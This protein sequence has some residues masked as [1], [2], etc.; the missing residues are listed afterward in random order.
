M[1]DLV[2]Y[3][4]RTIDLRNVYLV[5][6]LK[7]K[8]EKARKRYYKLYAQVLKIA[9]MYLDDLPEAETIIR[10]RREIR[11]AT[12]GTPVT[13]AQNSITSAG[14]VSAGTEQLY[15]AQS[16]MVKNAYRMLVPLV[17]PDLGGDNETFQL[18]LAA[19]RLK[20]LTFLQETYL[21]LTKDLF[22]WSSEEAINYMKQEIERPSVSL[23]IMQTT[24]VFK[25]AQAHIRK[26]KGSAKSKATSFAQRLVGQLNNELM[27]LITRHITPEENQN[28]TEEESGEE[29]SPGVEDSEVDQSRSEDY[30][31]NGHPW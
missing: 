6:K 13:I 21:S 16:H 28:G 15:N 8:M 7:A 27:Y 18:V 30:D 11:L 9:S 29:G 3:D 10:L 23:R 22:W 25:I 12:K 2:T 5:S 14:Y 24:D 4:R 1:Y 26:D 19:Y 31:E 17:H 20:D